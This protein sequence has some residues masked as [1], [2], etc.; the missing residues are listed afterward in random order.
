MRRF[1]LPA[2]LA[3]L[4]LVGSAAAAGPA[5]TKLPFKVKVPKPGHVKAYAF[6][7]R[8]HL[9]AG[10][11]VSGFS[12]FV[13]ASNG[14]AVAKGALA[15]AAVKSTG[16]GMWT[17]I[18]VVDMKHAKGAGAS[19]FTGNVNMSGPLGNAPSDIHPA[20]GNPCA[21]YDEVLNQI[22]KGGSAIN[23]GAMLIWV[24]IGPTDAGRK[25]DLSDC[26]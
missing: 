16:P 1:T 25:I 26:D 8:A 14:K 5:G 24:M 3:A 19:T 17:V 7:V 20:G 9:P 10:M 4:A 15:V 23:Q 11:T 18:V 13:S 12:P 21:A 22:G 6:A 2:V